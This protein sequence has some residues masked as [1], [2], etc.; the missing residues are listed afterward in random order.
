MLTGHGERSRVMEAVNVGVNE[1]LLKPVSTKALLARFV[2]LI[3]KPRRMVRKG[4][5]YGPEPRRCRATSRKP[6]AWS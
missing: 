5:Y 2:S 1:F 6:R 3:A 4:D